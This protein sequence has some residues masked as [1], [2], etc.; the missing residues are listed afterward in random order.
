MSLPSEI[1]AALERVGAGTANEG[2]PDG[3][4]DDA[5]NNHRR[6]QKRLVGQNRVHTENL[7]RR[8]NPYG[9]VR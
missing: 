1:K 9:I 4:K 8:L 2:D 5:R 3:D 7:I 6:R